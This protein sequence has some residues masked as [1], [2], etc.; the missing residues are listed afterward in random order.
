VVLEYLLHG[1]RGFREANKRMS[2]KQIAK[3]RES[4]GRS[5]ERVANSES[6]KAM[7]H[8]IELFGEQAFGEME[9][10]APD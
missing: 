3:I 8:D 6:F 1:A 9:R 5:P 7:L 4:M 10:E 2:E